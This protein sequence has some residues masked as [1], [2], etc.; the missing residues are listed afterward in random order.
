MTVK[1][2]A[3]A[4]SP[5][6]TAK[7]VALTKGGSLDMHLAG[8]QTKALELQVAV[9]NAM[10]A[11][12]AISRTLTVG[13]TAHATD[14]LNFVFTPING[15]ST[16]LSYVLVSGDTLISAASALATVINASGIAANATISAAFVGTAVLN[17]SYNVVPSAISV[18]VSGGAPTTTLALGSVSGST[19]NNNL[20]ALSTLLG[21]LL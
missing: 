2:D 20:A 3:A 18:N 10:K 6:A 5:S 8:I 12:P 15:T 19:D 4:F 7:S 17:I 11:H 21:E 14:S 16:T 9:E 1:A 13:G